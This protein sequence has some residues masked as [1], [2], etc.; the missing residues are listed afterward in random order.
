MRHVLQ[1]T[2]QPDIRAK[3]FLGRVLFGIATSAIGIYSVLNAEIL[4]YSVPD[5]LLLG[6]VW[7]IATGVILLL[8][9]F[10]IILDTGVRKS[11]KALVF[12]W[13]FVAFFVYLPQGDFFQFFQSLVL[14]G[15][16]FLLNT[17]ACARD[18]TDEFRIDKQAQE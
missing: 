16:A 7:V 4:R 18:I 9:G 14:V 6:E 17:V 12:I 3:A 11:A 1:K 5:F 8:I 15:G 13:G 2:I 10:L